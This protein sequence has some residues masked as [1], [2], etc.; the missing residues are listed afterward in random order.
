M[1]L[2]LGLR[3]QNGN[4][5]VSSIKATDL[6]NGLAKVEVQISGNLAWTQVSGTFTAQPVGSGGI[7]V[8]RGLVGTTEGPVLGG[9]G[10]VTLFGNF[11]YTPSGGNGPD[12]YEFTIQLITTPPGN[13]RIYSDIGGIS[14]VY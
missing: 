10:P 1:M 5:V 7:T 11:P 4:A 9:H 14:A 6:G 2:V 3:A 13:R 12:F 8:I